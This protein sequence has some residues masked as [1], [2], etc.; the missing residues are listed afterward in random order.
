MELSVGQSPDTPPGRKRW[1]WILGITL[2]AAIALITVD[3]MVAD[4][5]VLVT[6]E[7]PASVP[8]TA[9]M[10]AD[11][12]ATLSELGQPDAFTI[13]FF[14]DTISEEPARVETWSYYGVQ[15]EIAFID[16]A[17]TA[18]ERPGDAPTPVIAAGYSPA[19]FTAFMTEAQVAAAAGIDEYVRIEVEDEVV[20]EG[21][22][23]VARNLLF[24][25]KNGQLIYVE[26]VPDLV[27]E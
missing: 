13:Y 20:S 7:E 8:G 22:V 9:A 24:G 2:V 6:V 1:P 26:A 15:R 19:A 3:W 27:D 23:Y 18:E 5:I 10:S 11:Q 4:D 25:L 17:I 14:T 12:S 16:G 21:V